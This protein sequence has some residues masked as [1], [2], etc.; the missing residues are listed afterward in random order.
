MAQEPERPKPPA[1]LLGALIGAGCAALIGAAVSPTFV[2][3]GRPYN[4][5]AAFDFL[6]CAGAI[7]AM[8][9]LEVVARI[10]RRMNPA[11]PPDEYKQ[12]FSSKGI[13]WVVAAVLGLALLLSTV[14]ALIHDAVVGLSG[15]PR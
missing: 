2:P 1:M 14:V 12:F 13:G 3:E 5:V 4:N 8:L 10:R 9:G 7:S 11:L 15:P 6:A